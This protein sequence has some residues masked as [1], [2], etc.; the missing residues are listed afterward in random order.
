MSM[1]ATI[2]QTYVTHRST[3]RKQIRFSD[4]R[5]ISG[6]Q[7]NAIANYQPNNLNNQRLFPHLQKDIQYQQSHPVSPL[8]ALSLNVSAN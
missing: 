1:P 7:Q 2:N 5:Y 4:S 3:P 6:P 8:N